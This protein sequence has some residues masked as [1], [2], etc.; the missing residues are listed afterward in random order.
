MPHAQLPWANFHFFHGFPF[1]P[2]GMIHRFFHKDSPL[3]PT[4]PPPPHHPWLVVE[5][6]QSE[7]IKR[8]TASCGYANLVEFQDEV[9]IILLNF[10]I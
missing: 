4:R 1:Q 6:N 7:S 9:V 8:E 2:E 10:Y 5:K 3:T